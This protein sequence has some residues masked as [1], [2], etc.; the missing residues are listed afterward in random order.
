MATEKNIVCKVLLADK[1]SC[2]G[3]IFEI[4]EE[5]ITP[6][7]KLFWIYLGVYIFL[8]LFAGKYVALFV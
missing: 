5:E 7:D 1:L 8:R 4:A 3:T 6:D 2:N